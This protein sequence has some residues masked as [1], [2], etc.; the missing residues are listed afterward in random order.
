MIFLWLLNIISHHG[1]SVATLGI[2]RR[3]L[4]HPGAAVGAQELGVLQ[5]KR[6]KRTSLSLKKGGELLRSYIL[7]ESPLFRPCLPPAGTRRRPRRRGT[8]PSPTEVQRTSSSPRLGEKIEIESTRTFP[9]YNCQEP[10]IVLICFSDSE[11]VRQMH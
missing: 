9:T 10:N 7:F 6:D 3:I 4:L 5:K 11:V 1:E 2:G 8:R